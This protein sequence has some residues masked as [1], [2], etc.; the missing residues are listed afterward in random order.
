ML[1][2]SQ[3]GPA[4]SRG[5]SACTSWIQYSSKPADCG[6][7]IDLIACK[8]KDAPGIYME[9]GGPQESVAPART[10]Y[11]LGDC[12]LTSSIASSAQLDSTHSSPA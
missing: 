11:R 9:F 8:R 3:L 6:R 4:S 1:V 7:I 5:S 12:F 2:S 10:R